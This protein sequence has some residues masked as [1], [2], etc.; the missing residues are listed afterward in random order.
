ME[1]KSDLILDT[2]KYYIIEPDSVQNIYRPM[3]SVDL[4]QK[5]SPTDKDDFN[6]KFW[7]EQHKR[8]RYGW[9]APD[10][11]FINPIYYFFVN[12]VKIDVENPI[13]GETGKQPP[14]VRDNDMEIFDLIWENL[15]GKLNGRVDL[16]GIWKSAKNIIEAKGRRIGWTQITLSG[17]TLWYFIFVKDR[18]IA[19]AYPDDSTLERERI[20]FRDA[21]NELHPYF[22]SH[23]EF[24][25]ELKID[26]NEMLVQGYDKTTVSGKKIVSKKTVFLNRIFLA[27]YSKD[28]GK[29]RGEKIGLFVVIEAGKH[30]NLEGIYTSNKDSLGLGKRKFGMMIIGGT[31]DAI[32]NES[33]DY[34]VMYQNPEAFQAVSHFSPAYMVFDGCFNY[35][36]GKSD[37]LAAIKELM[38]TRR[39]A[40][41]SPKTSAYLKECQERPISDTECF[42]P[43]NSSP[44]DTD[45][46]DSQV[47]FIMRNRLHNDKWVRGKLEWEVDV[48]EERTGKVIFVPDEA[49]SQIKGKWVVHI[50]GFPV[51]GI[52]NIHIGATDDYYKKKLKVTTS[53]SSK[54][55]M[56]IYRIP[57]AL[58]I[59]SDFFVGLYLDRPKDRLLLWEEWL[60]AT[61]YWG[62]EI[63][64]ENNDDLFV[65]F[66]I[67]K[68]FIDKIIRVNGDYGITV[69]ETQIAQ[70]TTLAMKFFA[71]GRHRRID[72]ID[73]MNSFKKWGS[74]NSD[75]ASVVHLIIYCLDFMKSKTAK[76]DSQENRHIDYIKFGKTE[77]QTYQGVFYDGNDEPKSGYFKFGTKN[78]RN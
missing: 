66:M 65:D 36:T 77:K 5:P 6:F 72:N 32:E 69:K 31:S 61:V 18:N 30:K 68:G 76:V 24:E 37:K 47:Q 26:N 64:H 4:P 74:S 41:L 60:K 42:N 11:K 75:I 49:S 53:S 22:R 17:L 56:A 39:M 29:A 20:V 8:C 63:M 70:M 23:N 1:Y 59:K 43:P 55:S 3:L 12:F 40:L 25:L 54:G 33:E 67:E 10:L 58:D 2:K 13:T 34:K 71:D 50:E 19:M 21:Y 9:V 73:I 27:T 35:N 16:E 28:S 48:Y 14:F 51:Y 7:K 78:A 44:Y 62:C 46:I 15:H 52:N 38:N 57:C 45:I